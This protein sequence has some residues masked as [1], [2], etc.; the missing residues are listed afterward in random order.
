MYTDRHAVGFQAWSSRIN[1]ESSTQTV[2]HIWRD[3]MLHMPVIPPCLMRSYLLIVWLLTVLKQR[4][5]STVC[6]TLPPHCAAWMP[7]VI[8]S[9]RTQQSFKCLHVGRYK[10]K[11]RNSI[12]YFIFN[13]WH[14]FYA[15]PPPAH[16]D[17]FFRIMTPKVSISTPFLFCWCVYT[18]L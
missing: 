5:V 1:T 13:A 16:C 14:R 17:S 8:S 18:H 9:A 15:P 2:S 12:F 11:I 10:E 3:D 4:C 7:V 6:V